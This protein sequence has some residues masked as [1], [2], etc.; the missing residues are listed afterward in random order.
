MRAWRVH[1]AGRPSAVLRLDEVPEPTPGPGE[2]RVRTTA[3]VCNFNE[4]DGCHGRYRTVDP[5]LPYVL[6]MEG[7][8]IVD[9]AGAGAEHWLGRR[10][11]ATATG[12]A[13]AHAEAFV[14]PSDMVFDAPAVLDDVGAA[15]FFFPFHL[16]HLGL[17]ERG[18]CTAGQTVVV[19][20]AAGGVGSA[21]VQLAKAAGARVIAVAGGAVKTALARSLGADVVV[22]HHTEDFE[23]VVDE[24]TDGRGVDLVFDGVGGAVATA[25]VRSLAYGGLHLVVGFASGIEAEEFAS[26][27]GR[28]LCFGNLSTG[29]VLLSYTSDPRAAR[30]HTGFNLTPRAVGDAVH[31]RLVELLAAGAIRPVVGRVVDVTELPGAL[32]AMEDRRTT[33][34]TVVRFAPRG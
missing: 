12:A 18:R 14:A 15:A 32:D 10:V 33:G 16:A 2:V 24:V 31:G 11:V 26:V 6:G 29:G 5:P 3:T 1:A 22:D 34:R 9:A 8:G 4:V 25:S 7:T 21:A 27:T 19:H 28:T 20:A 23:V 17:I 13:G 30:R